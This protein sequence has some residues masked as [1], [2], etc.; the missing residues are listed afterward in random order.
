MEHENELRQRGHA[1]G[2]QGESY[3][4]VKEAFERAKATAQKDDLI[5][6]GGSTYVVAEVL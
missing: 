6:V 4:S 5:F 2:M 1:Y 3:N